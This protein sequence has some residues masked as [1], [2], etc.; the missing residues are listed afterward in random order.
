MDELIVLAVILLLFL[1]LGALLGLI[2]FNK[3]RRLERRLNDTITRF[4]QYLSD[5][6]PTSRAE[7]GVRE[8]TGES[9]PGEKLSETLA[10]KSADE[11]ATGPIVDSKDTIDDQSLQD[12]LAKMQSGVGEPDPIANA[13]N[14]LQPMAQNENGG[15]DDGNQSEALQREPEKGR[16]LEETIGSLWAVWVGGL[17]LALGAVFLVKFSIDRGLLG[18]GVR[19]LLGLSFSGLLIVLGEWARRRGQA[20]SFTGFSKANIPAILTAAGTMGAFATIFA[21]YELYGML[22]ALL[23]FLGLGLVAVATTFAALLHGPL[24]AVLGVLASYA[25]PMLVSTDSPSIPGLGM[26]ILAVSA[27]GF[28]IGRLRLWKWLAVTSGVGLIIYGVIL[29]GLGFSG[30]PLDRLAIAAYVA[31][32]WLMISYVFIVSLYEKER[33]LLVDRPVAPIDKTATALMAA[34]LLLMLGSTLLH[35]ADFVSAILLLSVIVGPFVLAYFYSA[36]RAGI[37][38]AMAVAAIGYLGWSIDITSFPDLAG[39]SDVDTLLSDFRV[40]NNIS[41]FIWIGT[42]L[43]AAAAGIGFWG[44]KNSLSRAALSI[45]G[46]FLPLLLLCAN[47]IR[48]ETFSS[49]WSFAFVA[50]AMFTGFL[51]ISNFLYAKIGD[52]FEG[53]DGAAAAYSVAAFVA[54]ALSFSLIL[55][56]AA[57]TIALAMLVPVIAF[58]YSR[59][60]LPALRPLVPIASLLWIGRVIWDPTIVGGDIGTTPIFNWLT[61]G[62]GVP[63]LGFAIATWLMGKLPSD[64]WVQAMEAITLAS[65]VAT[66]GLVGLHAIRPEELFTPFDTLEEMALVTI[67][68]GGVALGLLAIKRTKTSVTLNRATTILGYLGMVAAAGGLMVL[69]NPW[70]SE[71]SFGGGLIFNGLLFAYVLPALIYLLLGWYARGRRP[72]IYVNMALIL[73]AL[74]IAC[75]INLSIRHIYHPSGLHTGGTNDSELYTYSV[76]WLLIGIGTLIAGIYLRNK[77]L[78]MVS[79]GILVLV[80]AK[81]FLVDMAGLEGILRALSFIGLGATLIGIGLVYQRVLSKPDFYDEE[82]DGDTKPNP[83]EPN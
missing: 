49:S 48:T 16:N 62:Y 7:N 32:S 6:D 11:V 46:T 8:F 45:G 21:A 2:A 4:A 70:I 56:K 55:E 47:Y 14:D 68:G 81:V 25:A 1:M 42:F 41:N 12:E 13:E 10:Q 19:I 74:L 50:L 37:H 24:L 71:R 66:L 78:R 31:V 39:I 28:V 44:A 67:I 38:A 40:R 60:P 63:T 3:V 64:R 72:E 20:F 29:H 43:A 76:V 65:F 33:P 73:G 5:D 35:E 52:E 27:S 61:Y 79:V 83:T 58:V 36:A 80:V 26:Y 23:A 75:W 51:L 69:Y 54:L 30:D 57:L 82:P 17:A 15:D 22:P 34:I 59:R 53:R 77:Q 9:S 18:P